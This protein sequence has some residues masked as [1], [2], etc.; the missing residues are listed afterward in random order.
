MT[1]TLTNPAA[2]SAIDARGVTRTRVAEMSEQLLSLY[3]ATGGERRRLASEKGEVD[4]ATLHGEIEVFVDDVEGYATSI[5]KR[6]RVRE[7]LAAMRRLLAMNGA[8]LLA[9]LNRCR[10]SYPKLT[11]YVG[12]ADD[13]RRLVIEFIEKYD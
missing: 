5:A 3:A 8:R 12:E 2:E 6:G 13:L 1:R 7:P 10:G 9:S 11:R 4:G